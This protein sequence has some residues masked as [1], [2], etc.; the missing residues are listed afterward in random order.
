MSEALLR[1]SPRPVEAR[2]RITTREEAERLVASA[3]A[4]L[5][6]LQPLVER[7]TTLLRLGKVRTAL[8]DSLAKNEAAQTYTRLLERLKANAIALGRF[9]P[10]NLAE[11]RSRHE[12]FSEALQLNMAVI[13]T[14]RTVSEG[15]LRELAHQLG[16]NAAPKTYHRGGI[17]RKAGTLPLS[18]SVVS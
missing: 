3:L 9:A 5:D 11:L 7:E 8:G 14:A 1:Q 18:V 16:G 2:L 12:G 4:A 15:I 10:E 13:A 17:Q 6:A